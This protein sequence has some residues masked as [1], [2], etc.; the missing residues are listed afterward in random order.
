MRGSDDVKQSVSVEDHPYTPFLR[1][2]TIYTSGGPFL[3]GY[4][5]AIIGAA[6]IQLKP[7]IKLDSFWL[8]MDRKKC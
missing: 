3:D 5:L 1:K 7:F 4:I 2:L 6:L 8:G